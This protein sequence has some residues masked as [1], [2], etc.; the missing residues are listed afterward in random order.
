[1]FIKYDL[2][3]ETQTS[4]FLIMKTLKHMAVT[5]LHTLTYLN[6][7]GNNAMFIHYLE[8]GRRGSVRNN[9]VSFSTFTTRYAS[10]ICLAKVVTNRLTLCTHVI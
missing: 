9:P 4:I 2:T 5:T 8:Y 3:L 7:I 10:F 1:M 6:S